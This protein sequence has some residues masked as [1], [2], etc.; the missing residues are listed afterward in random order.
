MRDYCTTQSRYTNFF[1]QFFFNLLLYC[2]YRNVFPFDS[3]QESIEVNFG[4]F[5][6]G[7]SMQSLAV[8]FA[9]LPSKLVLVRCSRDSVEIVTAAITFL[10]KHK[11]LH[12]HLHPLSC[13]STIRVTKTDIQKH[14][15]VDESVDKEKLLRELLSKLV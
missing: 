3:S 11:K 6:I 14:M 10:G 2:T 12:V 13:R 1:T 8:L 7:I 4:E 9:N 5:G 15:I